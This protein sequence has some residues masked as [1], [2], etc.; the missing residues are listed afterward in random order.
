MT[1]TEYQTHLLELTE[2]VAL[3]L[4]R[5]QWLLATAESCTG[6]WLAKCCTDLTGSSAWFERGF[7]TYSNQSKHDLL[8]V[9]LGTLEHYGAVSDQS[10]AEMASGALTNSPADISVAIT[11]VAG[12]DGGSIEKPVG[13][14]W[15]AWCLKNSRPQT[16]CLQLKG[17]REQIRYQAVV[18]ALKG[19]IKNARD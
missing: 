13:T 17:D 12:P 15:V 18:A 9:S 4:K 6:G 11:G 2:Q 10:A 8:G 5:K 3:H 16:V 19:I 7:V 14:V 1:N